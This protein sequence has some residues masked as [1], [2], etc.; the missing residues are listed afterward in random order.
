[1]SVMVKKLGVI[2]SVWFKY[3]PGYG[4]GQRFVGEDGAGVQ[5]M[6]WLEM[7]FGYG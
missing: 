1:M 5:D 4:L 3:T 7:G 6:G 2:I